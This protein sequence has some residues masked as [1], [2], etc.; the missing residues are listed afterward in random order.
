[1]FAREDYVEEAWRIV[2]PVLKK[3]TPVY[4]YAPSTWGPKEVD[5][6]SPPGGWNNRTAANAEDRERGSVMKI[7]V[8]PRC[9]RGRPTSGHIIASDGPT[10]DLAARGKFVMAV[11]GGK[12][13][14]TCCAISRVKMCRGRAYMCRWTKG[15]AGG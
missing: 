4:Q 2:E 6:V 1:M 9:R 11:S 3:N 14:W 7:E 13:R 10:S 12:P 5:R 15:R 8:F